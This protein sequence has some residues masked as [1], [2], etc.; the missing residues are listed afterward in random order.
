M[1][2]ATPLVSI[3]IPTYNRAALIGRAIESALGQD[4]PNIEILISD[5][6]STDGTAELCDALAAAHANVRV[7][8]QE[9]NIGATANFMAVL[10][11]AQGKY[12]MWLGDDDHIDRHYIAAAVSML[13]VDPQLELVSGEAHYYREGALAFVGKRFCILSPRGW[14]R[15]ASYYWHVTDNGVFYGLMR[16]ATIRRL[17]LPNAMGGDWLFIA[18]VAAA[19]RI[20]MSR[21][22]TVHRELGGASNSHRDT[23]RALGLSSLSALFPRL[24]L[25]WNACRDA[26]SGGYPFSERGG[27]RKVLAALVF[28]VILLKALL[29][30]LAYL[31]MRCRNLL[32]R[33]TPS[34]HMRT[35]SR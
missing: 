32:K 11:L 23:A 27:V 18:R 22:M 20:V 7:Q 5:N 17:E 8:H 29:E 31:A 10:G 16:I 2:A 30:K 28:C 21:A 12:F 9:R 26:A 35:G 19:G 1:S 15:M 13:E 33:L 24:S 14:L 34:Y 3:G 25:A 4:Y 6:A